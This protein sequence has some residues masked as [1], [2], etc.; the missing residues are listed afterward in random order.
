M[1]SIFILV[2][3]IVGMFGLGVFLIYRGLFS[4]ECPHCGHRERK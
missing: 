2:G 3:F 1:V 4:G